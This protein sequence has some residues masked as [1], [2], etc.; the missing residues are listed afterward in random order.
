MTV[1]AYVAI[2]YAVGFLVT[3]FILSLTAGWPIVQPRLD[4]LD[5]SAT[6]FVA[7]FWPGFLV[8]LGLYTWWVFC[9][10]AGAKAHE[11][12]KRELERAVRDE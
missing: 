3:P 12:L 8:G 4:R 9:S 1:W 11:A 10:A 6:F 5:M 7:L 2:V